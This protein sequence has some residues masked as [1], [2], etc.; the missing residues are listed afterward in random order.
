MCEAPKGGRG[1]QGVV[2]AASKFG[3]LVT[4]AVQ[5]VEIPFGIAD[6][7]INAEEGYGNECLIAPIGVAGGVGADD[8]L[9]A[10]FGGMDPVLHQ[11][12]K[13]LKA[14]KF[15]DTPE[16]WP[17]FIYDFE[18]YLKK[19]SPKKKKFATHQNCIYLKNACHKF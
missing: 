2:A 18:R 14:P 10:G 4:P 6:E 15:D 7:D 9:G 11:M 3:R 13:N 8:G 5:G 1:V 12:I 19:L 17:S 16:N